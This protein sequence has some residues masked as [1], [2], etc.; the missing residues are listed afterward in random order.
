MSA[1][2]PWE[3]VHHE[4]MDALEDIME[5]ASGRPLLLGYGYVH[6]AKRIA[7]KF[8]ERPQTCTG[9]SFLSSSLSE[10]ALDRILIDWRQNKI[11][12]LCGHPA[13]IGHGLNLQGSECDSLVWFSLPWSLELYKQ[14][15]ARLIGGHRRQRA[16][17]IHHLVA[18]DTFDEV[19]YATLESKHQTQE[20]LKAAVN[21]YRKRRGL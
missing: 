1:G 2:G 6:E 9:A 19:V 8:P 15:N 4:K 10:K 7:Q 11:Q 20:K 13:S 18:R 16:T 17:V 3:E 21:D 5:E 14:M 12:L